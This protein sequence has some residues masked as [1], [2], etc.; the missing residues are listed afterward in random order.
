MNLPDIYLPFYGNDFFNAVE[1]YDAVIERAYIRALWHYWHVNHC[2][3]LQGNTE[4]LRGICRV[5][6]DRW[7]EVYP[8][9]FGEFFKKIA[10]AWH[11]KR[12]LE[13]W[14]KAVAIIEKKSNGGKLGMKKRWK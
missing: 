12:A 13:E 9:I 1:G 14:Q 6:A 3:G 8:I 10:G 2:E 5:E 4:R 7:E 11:Q